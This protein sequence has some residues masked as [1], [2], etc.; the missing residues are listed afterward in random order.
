[1][2]IPGT[3]YF[4]TTTQEGQEWEDQSVPDAAFSHVKV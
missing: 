4:W 1:M 2:L 3:E